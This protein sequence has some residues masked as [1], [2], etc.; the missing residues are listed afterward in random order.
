[1]ILRDN[2]DIPHQPRI[3]TLYKMLSKRKDF[4]ERDKEAYHEI[5]HHD[6][7]VAHGGDEAF[8]RR[9]DIPRGADGNLDA[10]A[11][12]YRVFPT[13]LGLAR[14]AQQ[15]SW[16]TLLDPPSPAASPAGLPPVASRN[17]ESSR[18]ALLKRGPWQVSFHYGQLDA[19]HAQAEAL[20]YEAFY[21]DTDITHDAGTVGYGSPLHRGY[22][23]TGLAHNV[24][25][26]GGH[27]QEKWA[28]GEL[29][30]FDA[31]AARVRAR[32]PAYRPGVSAE[33]ELRVEGERLIDSVRLHRATPLGA[34]PP[35][36]NTVQTK[37]KPSASRLSESEAAGCFTNRC[38][39]GQFVILAPQQ[40]GTSHV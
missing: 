35:R 29:L 14:A 23:Q 1:M 22:F 5:A 31:G 38:S 8:G 24:P 13:A 30:D 6:E 16:E 4:T 20:N 26:V 18:M 15:K 40:E 3:I 36:T 25:L 9:A 32:Q 34:R 2:K 12:V 37:R 11:G 21:G 27:G 7:D 28:R 19:S 33:R 17:L 10:L 39:T